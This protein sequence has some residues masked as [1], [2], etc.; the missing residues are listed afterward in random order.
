MSAFWQFAVLGVGVGAL[1]ALVAQGLVLIYRSSG[2][3]NFAHGAVAGV[4]GYTFYELQFRFSFPWPVCLVAGVAAATLVGVGMQAFVLRRLSHASPLMRVIATTALLAAIVQL[5]NITFGATPQFAQ[6]FLPSSAFAIGGVTVEVASVILTGIAIALTCLLWV[7]YRYS[8]FGLAT[9]A[10]SENELAAGVLG[11]STGRVAVI[12]WGIGS[13]LAGLAGILLA[14]LVS[15]TPS[16]IGLLVVPAL[17][18]ALIG[19]FSSF[20]LSLLGGIGVG[21]IQSELT[22]YVAA[23]GWADASPFLVIVVLMV[24]RGKAIPLRGHVLEKLPRVGRPQLRLFGAVFGFLVAEGFILAM[25]ANWETALTT[26]AI[27]ALLCASIVLL[28]GYAGQ[29]SLAQYA[30]AGIGAFISARLVA[31]AHVSFVP[32][33]ILGVLGGAAVGVIVGLPALR[34]RGVN[35]AIVTLGLGL[36]ISDIVF[37]NPS[38]TGGTVGTT[39]SAPAIFGVSVD[40]IGHP[41]RYATLAVVVSVVAALAVANIR[42]GRVGR[43]LL[44]VRSNERAAAALGISVPGAKLYAFAASSVIAA[45][46]GVLLAFQDPQVLFD[47][48]NVTNSINVVVQTVVLGVG[49]VAAAF[50]AGVAAP[51]GLIPQVLDNFVNVESYVILFMGLLLLITL[52]KFPN[53]VAAQNTRQFAWLARRL[54]GW[55]HGTVGHHADMAVAARRVRTATLHAEGLEI[56]FGGVRALSGAEIDVGPAEIVGLIGPN[57]AGKTSLLDILS[58][59]TKPQKG[60]VSFNGRS[61]GSWSVTRRARA[62]IGRSFQSLE[63]FDDL[64]VRENILAACEPRDLASYALTVVHPG[65]S[66]ISSAAAAAVADFGL[67]ANMDRY[68]DELSAGMRRLVGLARAVASEP[69]ILLLDEPAAGLDERETQELGVLL[70]RLAEDWGIGI[71]LVEHDLGLVL[72]VCDRLV[73]LDGGQLLVEGTPAEVAANPAVIEA[74]IGSASAGPSEPDSLPASRRGNSRPLGTASS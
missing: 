19:N 68:P 66:L 57:G 22:H 25:S 21:V 53:G 24:L 11:V 42:R 61:V 51:G 62:G 38:W 74:F 60:T 52:P 55:M 1:Y 54:P 18:A 14:P 12:N 47:Q 4:G 30:L 45:A 39:V 72:E 36:S 20:P 69:S 43:R 44:A 5:A 16:G 8:R 34:T 28:T 41:A 64:T 49:Y 2:V 29:L 70:R 58:G 17:A 37:G 63:L 7:C 67:T 3:V 23:P 6:S 26:T 65:R 40:P 59:F 71:V 35:L 33:A 50:M 46:A 10:V 73:V 56:S 31:A 9:T 15:L 32:A 13:A 27:F 48:Y